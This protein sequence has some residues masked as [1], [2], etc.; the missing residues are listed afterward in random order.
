M[1]VRINR[2]ILSI[3]GFELRTGEIPVVDLRLKK[4][5]PFV[6]G[7]SIR[8]LS[9]FVGILESENIFDSALSN[10]LEQ[11]RNTGNVTPIASA[12]G[13]GKGLT[14]SG[15]DILV[16]LLAALDLLSG[17]GDESRSTQ[18]ETYSDTIPPPDEQGT[19]SHSARLRKNLV[20]ALPASLRKHT[21]M[22]S[23]Q[24]LEAAIN[25]NYPESLVSLGDVLADSSDEGKLIRAA[26]AVAGLGHESGRAMLRGF[27]LGTEIVRNP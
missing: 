26:N 1:P 6:A 15:D 23:A 25:G 21:T 24:M 17:E 27:V 18:T 20:S 16:G 3:D 9:R 2:G 8:R 19:G 22:L 13:L 11:C 10:C 12:L 5:C 7:E 14:P 4:K